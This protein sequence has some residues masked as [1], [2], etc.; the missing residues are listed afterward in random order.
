[1]KSVKKTEPPE[2]ISAL[3][4]DRFLTY[5]VLQAHLAL[6]RQA[7]AI[8]REISG[9]GLNEWRVLAEVASGQIDS[10]TD[11]ADTTGL[12]RAIISR[13]MSALETSGLLKLT[14]NK[15]DRRRVDI[16]VTA[17]GKRLYQQI[18]PR[19]QARQKHLLSRLNKTERKIIYGA[20]E[21]IKNAAQDRVFDH[22]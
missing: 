12:D 3:P 15:E 4:V 14:R 9:L 20:L 7:I 19:M 21:K 17:K 10:N 8:L 13:S 11:L 22:E 18:L 2:D 5:K 1:V 16:A 6:N